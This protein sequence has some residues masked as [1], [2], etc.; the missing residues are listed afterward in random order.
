M[1]IPCR[2][3]RHGEFLYRHEP[4]Q[5]DMPFADSNNS[6]Q[7]I[8]DRWRSG[9]PQAKDELISHSCQRLVRLTRTIMNDFPPVRRWEETDDVFQ[10]AIMRLIRALDAV[11]PPS[12]RDF[13]RLAALQ[14]RRQLIDLSR[15]YFGACGSGRRHESALDG[16]PHGNGEEMIADEVQEDTTLDPARLAVWTQFHDHVDELA[17]DLR[18]MFDLVWYQGLPLVEVARVLEISE[19]TAQ[20]RWQLVRIE[21]SRMMQDQMPGEVAPRAPGC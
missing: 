15:H 7:E 4:S 14:I 12:V 13:F 9:D 6:L 8:L 11:Q 1:S 17:H 2:R 5:P 20:R 21:L 19:R 18:E 16:Q 3:L 10:A